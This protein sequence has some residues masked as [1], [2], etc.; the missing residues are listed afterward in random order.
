MERSQ[1]MQILV[2]VT[3]S[4]R[5][6]QQA[7]KNRITKVVY[8]DYKTL[9]SRWNP[10]FQGPFAD[11]DSYPSTVQLT[12]NGLVSSGYHDP[13]R[14][15]YFSYSTAQSYINPDGSII[16]PSQQISWRETLVRSVREAIDM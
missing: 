6:P 5:V 13:S 9:R 8:F 14:S 11:I 16:C 4:H 12:M 10:N 7:V 2:V 15:D 3:G 1:P